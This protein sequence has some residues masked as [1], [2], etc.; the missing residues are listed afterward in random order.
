MRGSSSTGV[1]FAPQLSVQQYPKEKVWEMKIGP[2]IL[3]ASLSFT[4]V[5]ALCDRCEPG[6][7]STPGI[8]QPTTSKQPR[9]VTPEECKSIG[10]RVL[11]ILGGDKC[12]DSEVD[13]GEV[14]GMRC[15]CVCC[16]LNKQNASGD[17]DAV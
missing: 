13:A 12:K 2:M 6:A 16:V 3:L 17:L 14:T 8:Q 4:P 15:K 7:D 9:T 11:N 5:L 10:G 1:D